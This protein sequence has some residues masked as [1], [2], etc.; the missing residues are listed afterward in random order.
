[1]HKF[2]IAVIRVVTLNDK[3]KL[4][5]HGRLIERYFPNL[6][7]TSYC[8]ANQYNGVHDDASHTLAELKIEKIVE[9]IKHKYQGIV[10]SCAGDP[11]VD[12]LKNKI[13]IPI[14]GAGHSSA[15]FCF[16]YGLKIGI[17]GIR[18]DAPC[19]IKNILRNNIIKFIKPQGVK[20]TNDLYTKE[21]QLAIINA[22]KEL[23][24]LGAEVILLACTGMSTVGITSILAKQIKLPIIDPVFAEAFTINTLCLQKTYF[25]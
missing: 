13:D 6:Q 17:I 22:A 12:K 15:S 20:N 7:T 23:K 5:Q 14:I 21:G 25:N 11:C 8:I 2:K 1:M 3:E 4:N 24:H 10:V 18:D 9:D 19:S 16:N